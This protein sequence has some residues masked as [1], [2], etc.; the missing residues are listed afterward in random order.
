MTLDYGFVATFY[1]CMALASWVFGR[2]NG[3]VIPAAL[4]AGVAIIAGLCDLIEDFALEFLWRAPT[5]L[6]AQIANVTS[7]VKFALAPAALLFVLISGLTLLLRK[8]GV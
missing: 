7:H 6:A 1:P 8:N 2:R 3:W 5:D 4:F